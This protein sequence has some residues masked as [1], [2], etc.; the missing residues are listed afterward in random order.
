MNLLVVGGTRFLGRRI[1]E[2]AL[3]RKH[4]VTLF[5]RGKDGADL[6]DGQV[7]RIY[8]D[9]D[10]DLQRLAA[11]KFDAVI[12]TPGYVPRVVRASAEYLRDKVERYMFISSISA[13]DSPAGAQ[14]IDED[15]NLAKLKDESVEEITPET[16][17]GLKVLCENVVND[18]YGSDATIVRPGY[19]VGS[20]DP[21]DRFTYYPWRMMQGGRMIAG[22]R[23]DAPL[24]IIDARDIAK[25]CVTL[26]ERDADGTFN[27]CGP[28]RPYGWEEWLMRAKTALRAGVDLEWFDPQKLEDAGCK[29]G[30]DLPLYN[31]VDT[32]TDSFMRCDNSKAIARGLTF[33][34]LDDT[35][36]DLIVW[37]KSRGSEALKV[38]MTLEREQ[39]V[40]KALQG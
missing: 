40:F 35:V 29:P 6:F 37:L 28:D 39:E 9:R 26:L 33:T 31:G 8:G 13:Y 22:G 12:D 11:E 21:T 15:T 3:A 2:N 16:Y 27:V 17:G 14:T 23:K 20:Y 1:V 4:R 38:G 36:R 18:V 19:I 25:F 10:G 5:F 7:R 30:A 34:P 24:Q 32:S